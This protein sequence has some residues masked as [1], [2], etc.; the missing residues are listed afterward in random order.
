MQSLYIPIAVR[1]SRT[2]S[3]DRFWL[4]L[5]N[6]GRRTVQLVHFVLRRRAVRFLLTKQQKSDNGSAS[7]FLS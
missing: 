4:V 6:Q 5:F 2:T 3:R 1:C 7:D